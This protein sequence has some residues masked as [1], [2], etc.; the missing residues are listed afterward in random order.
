ML[1]DPS[2][3]KNVEYQDVA[4]KEWKL[5]REDVKKYATIIYKNLKSNYVTLKH[6][7]EEVVRVSMRDIHIWLYGLMIVHRISYAL[8]LGIHMGISKKKH[9]ISIIEKELWF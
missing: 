2:Y 4:F 3:E 9:P 1:F 5:S 8:N 6:G 7:D